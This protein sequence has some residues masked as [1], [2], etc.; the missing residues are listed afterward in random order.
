MLDNNAVL[1][2]LI[3]DE[4]TLD[5]IDDISFY[6]YRKEAQYLIK[7]SYQFF[8]KKKEREGSNLFFKKLLVNMEKDQT[9]LGI[10]TQI[11]IYAVKSSL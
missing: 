1:Y 10:Y 5:D 8:T 11:A 6:Q 9:T 2:E 4:D 7:F 3:K